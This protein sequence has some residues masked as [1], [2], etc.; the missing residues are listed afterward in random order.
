MASLKVRIFREGESKPGTT[1]TIPVKVF[2]VA[3]RFVPRSIAAVLDQEGIVLDDILALAESDEVQGTFMEIEQ[4][5]LR[6]IF[7]VER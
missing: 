1:I 5:G 2:R 6:F 4:E 3:Q 7:S